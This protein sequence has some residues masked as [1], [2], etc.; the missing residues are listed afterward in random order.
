MDKT[1]LSNLKDHKLDDH[2]NKFQVFGVA[3]GG[4]VVGMLVL[5]VVVLHFVVKLGRR[6]VMKHISI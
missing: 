1:T 4:M 3:M 2:D 5:L 6:V